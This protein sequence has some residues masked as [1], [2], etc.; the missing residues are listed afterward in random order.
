MVIRLGL[1]GP[2]RCKTRREPLVET[3]RSMAANGV[4]S[5][6]WDSEDPF[7]PSDD[8]AIASCR[9]ALALEGLDAVIETVAEATTSPLR[10][11][12]FIRTHTEIGGAAHILA[13]RYEA[14]GRPVI[15]RPSSIVRG[16][17]KV[18]QALILAR[19]GIDTPGTR[20][21]TSS[22]Q[23]AS[24]LAALG[25]LPLIVKDP[26]GSFC[27]G[28]GI[29]TTCDELEELA[30]LYL[31]RGRGLV[32]QTFTPTRFDWRIGVLDGQ[33]LFA[34]QYWM[35]PNS[36]KIR[37]TGPEGDIWGGSRP[38][39][40]AAAPESVLSSAVRAAVAMGTGLW[41]VDLKVIGD[42]T[43]VIEV[44]DNPNIDDA[45]EAA[46]PEDRVWAH[47]A[48]WF[49]AAVADSRAAP[50]LGGRAQVYAAG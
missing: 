32:L 13:S 40:L 2:A 30:A 5:I 8:R 10:D 4:I 9:A 1:V 38:I 43:L 19:A 36:W 42:R 31:A 18:H 39:P 46:I 26:G 21:L 35:A 33:P 29:A 47:L 48:A 20:L 7:S 25:G 28:I 34:I 24:A 49:S 23:L 27:S 37:E 12:C 41:G 11:G 17:D 22:T 14:H 3:K 45:C 15:D 44:N 50:Q 6:V 16:C